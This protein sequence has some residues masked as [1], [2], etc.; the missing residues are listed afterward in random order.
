MFS[1]SLQFILFV[2][3]ETLT[4]DTMEPLPIA[5]TLSAEELAVRR[6]TTLEQLFA[7]GKELQPLRSVYCFR[8][9]A[10]DQ[11]FASSVELMTQERK[12]CRFMD[13]ELQV[14][15]AE[16]PVW[17]AISGPEG[18]KNFLESMLNLEQS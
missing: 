17:L 5:C 15:A 6:T 13:F 8:C 18:T 1:N 2:D 9:D 16:G 3:T 12:C 14:R 7:G 11:I 10:S 4:A